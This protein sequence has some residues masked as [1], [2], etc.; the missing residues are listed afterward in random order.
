MTRNHVTVDA[1]GFLGEPLD[2]GGGVGDL[3]LG[4]GQRLALL[5]GH[6]ATQVVLVLHQQLEPA[7]Q[8]A[9]TFLGGQRAP[10]RQRLL[11]GLDGATGFRAAHLRYVA[12][13]LAGRR[14]VHG[15]GL[16]AVGIQPLAIDIGLL[17]EQLGVLQLH[18]S[19]LQMPTPGVGGGVI[20]QGPRNVQRY[21]GQV[22]DSE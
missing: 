2:E 6:Q 9:R 22:M 17:A 19:L 1:L 3:A 20:E 18:G 21:V 10:G 14:V 5:Q 4:L 13:D 7:T 16:A 12:D 15:D 11:G 8:L